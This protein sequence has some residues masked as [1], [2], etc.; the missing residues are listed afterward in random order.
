[1]SLRI[2]NLIDLVQEDVSLQVLLVPISAE[3][4]CIIVCFHSSEARENSYLLQIEY[5]YCV[6]YN[7]EYDI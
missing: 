6:F 3:I 1:M 7:I 4:R 5:I 2:L